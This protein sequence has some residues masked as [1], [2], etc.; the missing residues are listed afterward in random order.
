MIKINLL[1]PL[2]K[3]NLKWEK[4]NNLAVKNIL[5]VL[6]S[7]AIFV[8]IF[9]SSIEYLKVKSEAT[10]ARLAAVNAEPETKEVAS[11]ERAFKQ[12]KSRVASIYEAQTGHISWTGLFENISVLV[13]AGVKLEDV[14]VAEYEDAAAK[15]ASQKN[16]VSA[17]DVEAEGGEDA[18]AGSAR[19]EPQKFSVRLSG[20]AKTRE[21]LL[22]FEEK[23]KASTIFSDLEYDTGNYVKSTDIDF[24]YTFYVQRNDLIK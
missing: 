5:W 24:K 2:D 22:V 21:S 1:S 7:Q 12:N 13:P 10:A 19:I 6:L 4:V 14:A 3:E 17:A 11:I 15:K 23:L 18:D 8:G 9:F 16:D 20:N